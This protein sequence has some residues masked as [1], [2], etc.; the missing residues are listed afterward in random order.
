M[1]S[2]V[3]RWQH[4]FLHS[5]IVVRWECFVKFPDFGPYKRPAFKIVALV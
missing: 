2:Q 3:S 5:S 1:T 4:F